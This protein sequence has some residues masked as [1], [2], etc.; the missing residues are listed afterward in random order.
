M[1]DTSIAQRDP[2]R[3]ESLNGLG[4]RDCDEC[5]DELRQLKNRYSGL[6][7]QERLRLACNAK[8]DSDCSECP[9]NC[10]GKIYIDK[11]FASLTILAT[12]KG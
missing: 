8:Q 7:F 3:L 2:S 11:T 5:N 9:S 4:A 6:T 1:I 12:N 10:Q